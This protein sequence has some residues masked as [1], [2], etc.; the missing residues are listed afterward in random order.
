M[1]GEQNVF[2][3]CQAVA[4]GKR[5]RRGPVAGADLVKDGSQVLGDGAL[6]DG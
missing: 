1:G 6:A 3:L 4:D 5:R 2:L